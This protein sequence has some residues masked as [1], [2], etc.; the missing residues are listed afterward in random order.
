MAL[1]KCY[2]CRKQFTV[3]I[4]TIFEDS[5]ISVHI[6][7]QAIY[8]MCSSKLNLIFYLAMNATC[9]AL[10]SIK[11]KRTKIAN[12]DISLLTADLLKECHDWLYNKFADLGFN[13]KAA[14]GP[15]LTAALK[16]HLVGKYGFRRMRLKVR[17][18]A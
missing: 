4:G 8:L 15:D 5:H 10:K 17:S 6:W 11:P 14:K 9:S 18:G 2:V 7:R 1:Y 16:Q 12:L 13:D 3:K